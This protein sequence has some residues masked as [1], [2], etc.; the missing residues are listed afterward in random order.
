MEKRS[1]LGMA[2]HY[3]AMSE[4]LYRGYN[5]AVPAVD[6]GDDVYVVEDQQGTMWRLQIKTSDDV[7]QKNVGTYSLSRRQL[8]EIKAN[9]LFYMFMLRWQQR[10]RFVLIAREQLAL[11]RSGF[12]I[13]DRA[14]K[15][16]RKPIP[17]AYAQ[18]DTLTLMLEWSASDATGWGTSF[19][20]Y[21][22]KWP[23][24]FPDN[25]DGPGAVAKAP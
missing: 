8:R 6:V 3:A 1:H 15:R 16:G 11:I 10:W 22:D 2:G 14:G 25:P 18:T 19:A 20:P 13:A 5:V 24:T 7:A 17:D 21:L 23:D 12:E 9:E 4:F